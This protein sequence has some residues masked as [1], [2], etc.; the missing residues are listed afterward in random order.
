MDKQQQRTFGW[1]D[2]VVFKEHCCAGVTADQLLSMSVSRGHMLCMYGENTE[3]LLS[4]KRYSV[5]NYRS[6]GLFLLRLT[7]PLTCSFSGLE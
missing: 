4:S 7:D 2:G 6:L 1:Y 3:D 5:V